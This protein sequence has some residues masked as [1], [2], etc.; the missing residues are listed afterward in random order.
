MT[1]YTTKRIKKRMYIFWLGLVQSVFVPTIEIWMPETTLVL[2]L[3]AGIED[4]RD[5]EHAE[6]LLHLCRV[7]LQAENMEDDSKAASEIGLGLD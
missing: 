4:P 7:H 3:T 5:T 1:I 6:G 2:H